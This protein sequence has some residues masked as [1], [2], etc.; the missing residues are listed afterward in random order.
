M[1]AA[2]ESMPEGCIQAKYGHNS[3]SPTWIAIT[4]LA[5][6]IVGLTVVLEPIIIEAELLRT[7]VAQ[8]LCFCSDHSEPDLVLGWHKLFVVCDQLLADFVLHA[9]Q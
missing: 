9:D 1:I 8:M 6:T 3:A 2:A 7:L 5:R 4:A